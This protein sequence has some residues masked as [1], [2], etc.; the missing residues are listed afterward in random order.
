MEQVQ[1]GL[2]VQPVVDWP[3]VLQLFGNLEESE[4][5]RYSW[6][7]PKEADLK[8]LKD[9]IVTKH[10]VDRLIGIGCGSGFLERIIAD[11]CGLPVTGV[12]LKDSWWMSKF[13]PRIFVPI[14]FTNS[15]IDTEFSDRQ[16]FSGHYPVLVFCYFN[17]GKAFNEYL[18]CFCAKTLILIGPKDNV[19]IHTD[20][21]P[22][23][24]E[25]TQPGWT[26]EACQYMED[27][28]NVICIY[29]RN[30]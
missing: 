17:N 13:H 5:R 16:C 27:N 12:E 4:R 14:E 7:A 25:F 26:F 15:P 10:R 28:V 1:D 22:L 29:N 21:M 8:W 30:K 11:Y 3:V 24:P 20:P 9:L 6:V 2:E 18:S 19:G 23:S